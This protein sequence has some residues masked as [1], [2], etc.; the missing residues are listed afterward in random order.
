MDWLGLNGATHVSEDRRETDRWLM[1][2]GDTAR[3]AVAAG[4]CVAR[5]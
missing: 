1:F 4:S 5:C 2:R 3:N